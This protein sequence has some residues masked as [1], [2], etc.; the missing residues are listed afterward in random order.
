MTASRTTPRLCVFVIITGPSRNPDSSTHVVP[1]ISPL[2]LSDHDPANTGL[3]IEPLPRGITAVTPVR[4]GPFPICSLPSPEISVVCPTVTP[5]T[6]VIAFRGPGA[7]SNGTPRSRARG[8]TASC[9]A[10][11]GRPAKIKKPMIATTREVQ[12][13]FL[14]CSS[15]RKSLLC[16]ATRRSSQ[17]PAQSAPPA[18]TPA[19]SHPFPPPPS[20]R[21]TPNARTCIATRKLNAETTSAPESHP[22][23][24]S[25]LPLAKAAD[26]AA[27]PFLPGSHRRQDPAARPLAVL[28]PLSENLQCAREVFSISVCEDRPCPLFPA[29]SENGPAP[30]R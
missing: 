12:K 6:S 27:L 25:S 20:V 3:F 15:P 2:P 11:N 30:W 24:A 13:R 16:A 4:T 23:G 9:C 1:V 18:R 10:H 29:P 26:S 8:F 19:S 21:D 17:R 22:D 5:A 14:N 28:L 7:P